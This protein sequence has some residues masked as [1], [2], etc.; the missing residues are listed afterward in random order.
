M[1]ANNDHNIVYAIEAAHHPFAPR[2]RGQSGC[3]K[4]CQGGRI[5]M[6]DANG[7]PMFRKDFSKPKRQEEYRPRDPATVKREK[8][9]AGWAA[10]ARWKE[11]LIAAGW[12]K[13]P[14]A[15]SGDK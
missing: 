5:A 2:R 8:D 11:R 13:P 3:N 12:L 9:E 4:I 7:N 1:L 15:Q 6:K 10:L 14:K